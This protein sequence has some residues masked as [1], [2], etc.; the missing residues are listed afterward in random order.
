MDTFHSTHAPSV[1]AG[2]MERSKHNTTSKARIVCCLPPRSS[3]TRA[4]SISLKYRCRE[5]PDA[6]VVLLQAGVV[7]VAGELDLE[8]QLR[9]SHR[10]L[11][12]RTRA[13]TPGPPH[14]RSG[15]RLGSLPFGSAER[16]FSQRYLRP[17][18]QFRAI[19]SAELG[20][21]GTCDQRRV[22]LRC[23]GARVLHRAWILG[24]RLLS[25]GRGA[26]ESEGYVTTIE[27]AAARTIG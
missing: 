16:A 9:R 25:Q 11:A 3:S 26:D 4:R 17:P 6:N 21:G 14:V 7:A 1:D 18:D 5:A 27:K 13:P 12:D 20:V 23:G 10:E 19:A 22:D 2:T 24:R 15:W 8:L